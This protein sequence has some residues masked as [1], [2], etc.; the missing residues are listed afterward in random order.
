M[1]TYAVSFATSPTNAA[2]ETAS[3]IVSERINDHAGSNFVSSEDFIDKGVQV[4]DGTTGHRKSV[5]SANDLDASDI[6]NVQGIPMTVAQAKA[7][8]YS[9]D[10][11]QPLPL[12]SVSDT[13][14][15]VNLL[16]TDGHL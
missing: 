2:G 10:G 5:H 6:V 7:V 13:A 14:G 15:L 1:T 4:I 8:G 12:E 16:R 3:S 9:F 11:D